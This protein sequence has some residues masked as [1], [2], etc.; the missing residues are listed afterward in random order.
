MARIGPLLR[1]PC[2]GYFAYC[3]KRSA[4]SFVLIIGQ[5]TP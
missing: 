1:V 2:G 3:T 4:S 5:I